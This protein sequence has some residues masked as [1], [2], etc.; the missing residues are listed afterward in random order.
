MTNGPDLE[1]QFAA[2]MDRLYEECKEQLDYNATRFLGMLNAY[3]GLETAYRI[4]SGPD[5]H[6]GF[7]RVVME[8]RADLTVEA[9]VLEERF[10]PLFS[11]EQ[12]AVAE[13]RTAG[14]L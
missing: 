9:V 11:Q 7:T 12:I 10:R 2:E 14:L 4:L 13:R 6:D 3:G 8:G 5:G 1:R